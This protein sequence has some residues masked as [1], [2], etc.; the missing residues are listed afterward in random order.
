M[1]EEGTE[2]VHLEESLGTHGYFK[3]TFDGKINPQDSVG[4]SLYKRMWPRGIPGLGMELWRGGIW[5][6]EGILTWIRMVV[7]CCETAVGLCTPRK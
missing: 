2:W 6:A 1:D 4:V 3:A 7:L 5:M